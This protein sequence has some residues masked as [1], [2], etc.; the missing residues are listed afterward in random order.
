MY[1]LRP[2]DIPLANDILLPYLNSLSA[3]CDA[4]EEAEQ[5][6]TSLLSATNDFLIDKHLEFSAR[7]DGVRIVTDDGQDLDP[8][9]LSSGERQLVMLVCTA[10]L[11]GRDT[12]LLLIDEPE[13]S[14]GVAW[15]RRV[16]E[17]LLS[18]TKGSSLQFVVATHS[19]EIISSQLDYLVPLSR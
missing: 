15:Q 3:R 1:R 14:L 17:S 9:Q 2:E 8:I 13:L 19:I 10:I 12:R 4:L 11:A 5:L 18:L 7:K 16:L 6:V